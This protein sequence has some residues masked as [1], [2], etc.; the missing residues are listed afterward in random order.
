[1][2]RNQIAF[3]EHLEGKRHNVATENETYRNN[4]ATLSETNRHNLVWEAETQRHNTQTE[5]AAFEANAINAAHFQRMD[6][7]GHRSN[8]ANEAIAGI[9]ANTNAYN[10]MINEINAMTRQGELGVSQGQLKVAEENANT[11]R[12]NARTQQNNAE[13]SRV[14]ALYEGDLSKART[15]DY[16]DQITNRRH[17]MQ[18]DLINQAYNIGMG[19]SEFYLDLFKSVLPKYTISNKH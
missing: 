1:M 19:E 5:K 8:L 14:R 4:V 16:L 11:N 10:A 7:E 3:Q 12:I 18:F 6:Q 9:N 13:I 2:T 15:L 17:R